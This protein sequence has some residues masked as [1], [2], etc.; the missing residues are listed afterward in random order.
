MAIRNVHHLNCG[1]MCPVGGWL[2]GQKG[3]GRGRLVAHC[4]L[5]ETDR[6]DLVLIDTGF[7][8]RDVAHQTPL[9]RSFRAMVGPRLD[10][11]E[12]AIV[13]IRALGLDPRAVRHIVVTHLDVDHAG[14]LSDFPEARVHVHAREHAAAMA[15]TRPI[16]RQ[17]YLPEHW[18]HGPRWEVYSEDGDTWRGLPAITRLRGLDADVALVPM[19][20]H[21][22][23]HSAVIAPAGDRWLVHAGDAYFHRRTVEGGAAP[24]GIAAFER[25]T[26]I[27][28][29]ARR[30]SAAALRQLRE[31]YTDLD[32]FC[33]HDPVELDALAAAAP[34]LRAAAPRPA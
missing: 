5:L 15:R 19:H 30:A 8:T 32:V 10:A 2:L 28:G 12:P 9:R 21:T 16:E 7:G 14:G 17:R 26:Q 29:A 25:Y 23:G 18:S 4:V 3:L 22:R 24:I 20:G 27:D 34:A 31:H 11:D 6:D 33:A 13:Q 1:T